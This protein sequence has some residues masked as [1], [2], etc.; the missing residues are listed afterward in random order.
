[1]NDAPFTIPE[2]VHE[3]LVVLDGDWADSRAQVKGPFL[4]HDAVLVVDARALGEDQQG[5]AIRISDVLL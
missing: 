2:S 3:D 4:E 5:V 1:M